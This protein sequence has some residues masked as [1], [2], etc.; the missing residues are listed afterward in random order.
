M[1]VRYTKRTAPRKGGILGN[2]LG[3]VG[4]LA[5]SAGQNVKQAASA[6]SAGQ[7]TH[8]PCNACTAPA[9]PPSNGGAA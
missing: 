2:L 9:A 7:V 6:A 3:L 1:A 4:D 5:L 8:K